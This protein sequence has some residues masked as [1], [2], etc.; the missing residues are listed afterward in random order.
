M[1]SSMFAVVCIGAFL[2]SGIASAEPVMTGLSVVDNRILDMSGTY[3]FSSDAVNCQVTIVQHTDGSFG[4]GA[5]VTGAGEAKTFL[6]AGRLK[7][8]GN[9]GMTWS[10]SSSVDAFSL[11][12]K[13]DFQNVNGGQF[14]V[15]VSLKG[16]A[17]EVEM[18]GAIVPQNSARGFHIAPEGSDR[19][20]GITSPFFSELGIAN[21]S[22]PHKA[23]KIIV[24]ESFAKGKFA[25]VITKVDKV[26]YWNSG[27]GT[28]V[29]RLGKMHFVVQPSQLFVTLE[30]GNT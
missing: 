30:N 12:V 13:A 8:T 21:L 3:S 16:P 2:L 19:L 1:R 22:G 7:P 27:P 26:F 11:K 15:Q 28:S 9:N 17:F 18:S 14:A 25:G 23:S 6:T 20:R 4:L 29:L 24:K 10:A 5:Y